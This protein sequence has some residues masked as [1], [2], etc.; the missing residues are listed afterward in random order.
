MSDKFEKATR[1]KYRFPSAKGNLT[2]E[3]L[4]DLSLASLDTIAKQVHKGIKVNEEESFIPT[5]ASRASVSTLASN[6]LEILK[7]I[8]GVKVTAKE[9]STKRA[10]KSARLTK[11][12]ELASNKADEALSASSLAD[13]EK[14]I[15]DAE[16]DL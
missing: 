4:W 1:N 14:M 15:A 11:L 2:S 13:I 3:E 10:A 12:R 8:I 7:H 6:K 16:A 9:V 5:A